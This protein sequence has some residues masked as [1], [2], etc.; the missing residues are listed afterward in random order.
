MSKSQI[1]IL[2]ST[3][4][5]LD[6]TLMFAKVPYIYPLHSLALPPPKLSLEPSN[7]GSLLQRFSFQKETVK[8]HCEDTQWGQELFQLLI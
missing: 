7:H 1:R 2:V 4:S 6:T 3:C 5:L 8:P